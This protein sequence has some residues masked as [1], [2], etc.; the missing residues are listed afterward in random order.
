MTRSSNTIGTFVRPPYVERKPN[1]S[2]S[3][4]CHF[5][6][7]VAASIAV[8]TPQTPWANTVSDSGS[9]TIADHPTRSAGTS[10]R[11]TLKTLR[12]SSFPVIASRQMTIS[13]SSTV[14]GWERA[15]V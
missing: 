4:R 12:Q 14:S 5:V 11:Y 7:P 6:L 10:D 8:K 2:C 1:S 13:P 15:S 9:A 3:D